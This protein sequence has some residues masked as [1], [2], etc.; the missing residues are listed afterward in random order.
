MHRLI[1]LIF[2]FCLT[3]I[4]SI[5]L[6]QGRCGRSDARTI[7]Y[8][9][10]YY[11]GATLAL[12]GSGS[13]GDLREKDRHWWG[14][15]NDAISSLE[16]PDGYQ[17]ILFRDK[18][19]T[20]P[21]VSVSGHVSNLFNAGGVDWDDQVSSL[22]IVNSSVCNLQPKVV[23]YDQPNFRGRSFE[24]YA[25]E[26]RARLR[27]KRRGNWGNWNDR[28]ESVQIVGQI[29]VYLFED[30]HFSGQQLWL[31][32]SIDDLRLQADGWGDRASSFETTN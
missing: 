23:F 13:I 27:D 9:H 30:T 20:G 24:V 4:E 8:E 12:T 2:V 3:L 14:S 22:K 21:S 31:S 11:S 16:I 10:P 29:D 25:G 32:H 5:V 17:A 18:F 19:F 15:W 26:A 28:I 6:A 7:I 1:R